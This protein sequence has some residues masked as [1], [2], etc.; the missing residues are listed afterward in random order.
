MQKSFNKILGKQKTKIE[1]RH[2]KVPKTLK[3]PHF[4]SN[5]HSS[6]RRLSDCTISDLYMFPKQFIEISLCRSGNVYNSMLWSGL[7]HILRRL[8]RTIAD[9]KIHVVTH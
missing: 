9:R 4:N 7:V 2:L 3:A 1:M 8:V 5:H 6:E